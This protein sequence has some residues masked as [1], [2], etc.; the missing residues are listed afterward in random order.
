M[1]SIKIFPVQTQQNVIALITATKMMLAGLIVF[2]LINYFQ[3]PLGVWAVVTIAAVTQTGLTQTLSKSLMRTIGTIIGAVMGYTIAMLANGDV[4]IMM[5][6]LLIVIWFSSYIALQPTIY[7]YAGI[8]TGMTI[9]IVLFFSITHQDFYAVAVDRSFE[10]LLG[11]LVIAVLNLFLFYIVKKYYPKGMTKKIISWKRPQF[12]IK[13]QHAVPATKVALACLLTFVIWYFFKLPAGYWA[14][15]TC[16][17]IME[18]SHSVTFKK[19]FFRFV[20]HL[21]VALIGF[22]CVLALLHFSYEWRLLP[23]LLTFF[24]CGFL[25]GTENQYASMGNTMG[26]AMAI[27]LLSDPGSHE[28]IKIIFERFYNVTIGIAVAFVMLNPIEK[29]F[30]GRFKFRKDRA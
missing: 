13:L 3:L 1:R 29:I 26:I 27:M 12:T 22:L 19:G 21:I 15:I 4:T 17:L 23:L 10:V 2:L 28:T 5:I 9:A 24:L 7:S 30:L 8:V 6:S 25:I 16:L 14:T 11:V 20:S 18:E